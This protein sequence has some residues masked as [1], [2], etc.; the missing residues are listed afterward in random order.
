[1]LEHCTISKLLWSM[2]GAL[3]LCC[4]PLPCVH[5]IVRSLHVLLCCCPLHS[6]PCIV[7]NPSVL[8]IVHSIGLC[9][10]ALRGLH[11]CCCPFACAAAHC[12]C[13]GFVHCIAHCIVDRTF[14]RAFPFALSIPLCGSQCTFHVLVLFCITGCAL[15]YVH[16]IVMMP[17]ARVCIA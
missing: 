2:F 13:I 10:I 7:W 4:C 8:S 16:S 12:L 14:H 1:M 3:H 5:C 17:I 6:G 15:H 11:L 9:C